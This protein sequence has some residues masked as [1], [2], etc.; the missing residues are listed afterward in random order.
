MP[1]RRQRPGSPSRYAGRVDSEE[2][3]AA[4]PDAPPAPVLDRQE[5][6][7]DARLDVGLEETFPASDPV[8]ISTS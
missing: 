3:A 1:E 7:L 2:K 5:A 4:K 6:L 8:S